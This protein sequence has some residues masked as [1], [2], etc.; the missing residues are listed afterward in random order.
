MGKPYSSAI[1]NELSKKI[2]AGNYKHMTLKNVLADP[3]FH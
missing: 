2:K 1:S 3:K